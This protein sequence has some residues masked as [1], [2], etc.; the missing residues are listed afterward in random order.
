MVSPSW[1]MAGVNV[2]LPKGLDSQN[3][4]VSDILECGK[5]LL[6]GAKLTS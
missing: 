4:Y 1:G 5:N 3:C 2:W 6:S